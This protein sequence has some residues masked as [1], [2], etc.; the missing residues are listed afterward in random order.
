MAKAVGIMGPK[1]RPEPAEQV[2]GEWSGGTSYDYMRPCQSDVSA[3]GA[4][5]DER[6][7]QKD[8]WGYPEGP[9][10]DDEEPG[11]GW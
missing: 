6:L 5:L 3:Y 4:R 2:H 11:W 7:R 1:P 8:R 9:L 10:T